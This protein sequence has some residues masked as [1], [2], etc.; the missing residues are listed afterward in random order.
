MAKRYTESEK[1]KNPWFRKLEPRLK[2]LWG[3][4]LDSCDCAG[5]WKEDFE[6]ASF[7]IGETVTREDLENAFMGRFIRLNDDTLFI[8]PFV[9]FQYGKLKPNSNP[10]QAV[11]RSLDKHGIKVRPYLASLP[12]S[13]PVSDPDPNEPLG[14]PSRTLPEPL[15]KGSPTL[16]DKDQDQDKVQA[17]EKEKAQNQDSA[18]ANPV[19]SP[20]LAACSRAADDFDFNGPEQIAQTIQAQL[21]ARTPAPPAPPPPASVTTPPA[22]PS[23]IKPVASPGP[24]TGPKPAANPDLAQPLF[25]PEKYQHPPNVE[26]APE[27]LRKLREVGL[28]A[29]RP[30]DLDPEPERL[31]GLVEWREGVA[32]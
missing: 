5:I 9:E 29:P 32:A 22:R 13:D 25:D 10:H 4:M 23:P 1:W 18:R 14:N 26:P 24:K 11:V 17:Q 28:G 16:K 2:L 20:E 8:R 6:L 12:G 19:S 30:A 3:Y 7:Q 15:L 27:I 31:F 21:D